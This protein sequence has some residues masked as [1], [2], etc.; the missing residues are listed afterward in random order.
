MSKKNAKI[1]AMRMKVPAAKDTPI[2]YKNH[3]ARAVVIQSHLLKSAKGLSSYIAQTSSQRGVAGAFK[4]SVLV[5]LTLYMFCK[6]TR[7][8]D[9]LLPRAQLQSFGCNPTGGRYTP[10][11]SILTI[12]D[13]D[14]SFSVSLASVCIELS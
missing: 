10:S 2:Q 3:K 7:A 1:K 9:A 5:Q 6:H 14:F 12:G 13:G 4:N 11:H 8:T